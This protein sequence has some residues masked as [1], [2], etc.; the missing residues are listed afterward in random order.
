[1][2]F[3]YS[4]PVGPRKNDKET[5]PRR[6]YLAQSD[7]WST[8][9][10]KD[11]V[12]TVYELMKQGIRDFGPHPFAGQRKFIKV[13]NE[14][15]EFEKEVDGSIE[16][17][18]KLWSFFELGPYEWW[19]FEQTGEVVQQI[20]SA[21]RFHGIQPGVEKFQ[22][23]AK[24]C[25][26]W[27]VTALGCMSI[28]VPIVTAYDTLGLEGLEESMLR[29]ETVGILT[30]TAN[31]PTL[32][33]AVAK[34]SHM[35][36]VIVRDHEGKPEGK[37][38]EALEAIKKKGVKALFFSEFLASGKS[39][40]AEPVP[41]KPDDLCCIM[42]TSG[43]TGPPKGVILL[44][45]ML[46]A[47]VA[48]ATGVIKTPEVIHPGDIF[49]NILPL[50]HILEVIVELSCFIWGAALGYGTPRTISDASMRNCKGDIRELRPTLIAG[51][52]AVFET[53]KK[54]I[55][56]MVNKQPPYKQKLFWGSYRAKVFC[57][58]WGIPLPLVDRVV[59]K[60][61]S[62]AT[63]GRIRYL[64][65][66][67]AALSKGSKL[68]LQTL[69]APPLMGYGLTETA[70]MASIMSPDN[71]NINDGGE[72][73]PSITMKL[74]DVADAGYFAKN[75]QG[76]I[77]IKGGA[78][79]HGYFQNPEETKKVFTSDGWFMT[80]DV[81]EWTA[82]GSLNIIDRMKNLVKTSS[83]EYIAIERLES[84]YRSNEYI[85]N[86]CMFADSE[87]SKPVAVIVIMESTVKD[88]CRSKGIEFPEHSVSENKELTS[89]IHK[90][91]QATAKSCGMR[92]AEVLAAI[93]LSDDEWTP[94][95][96]FVSSAQKLQRRKIKEANQSNIDKAFTKAA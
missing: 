57:Q 28:S 48:G 91:L 59:F 93:T 40:P 61:I 67:G 87:H 47:S 6:H 35:R 1:M 62:D 88:L 71:Y 95:N 7:E 63:G 11:N 32:A 5:A 38:L 53:I 18:T 42:Y 21:L 69:I 80:G 76:E 55:V 96:G 75:G 20:G 86:I 15:K 94:Q 49:L 45:K 9:E 50:A 30:D 2:A 65:N 25:R 77:W 78:V 8:P 52:P 79:S 13:H 58:S 90:S 27:F 60:K 44:H 70:A 16:K 17:I 36:L 34:S 41:P 43:S 26:E 56:S 4:V 22:I 92:S 39:N 33:K 83:G 31:L 73:V 29:T 89:L 72:I 82:N 51:V 74:V 81:G 46:V 14:E 64:F 23:Y 37:E 12:T 10:G 24:T 84:L 68:F 54:G 3:Q 19:T 85:S 66:G